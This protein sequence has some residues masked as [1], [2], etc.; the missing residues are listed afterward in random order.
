MD[1]ISCCCQGFLLIKFARLSLSG[2]CLLALSTCLNSLCSCWAKLS[3]ASKVRGFCGHLVT[4]AG[5]TCGLI[6]SWIDGKGDRRLR[7]ST[8]ETCGCDSW[9]QAAL[10]ATY[11]SRSPTDFSVLSGRHFFLFRCSAVVAE[12]ATHLKCC[13]GEFLFSETFIIIIFSLWQQS[14]RIDRPTI[15]PISL[16][17]AWSCCCCEQSFLVLRKISGEFVFSVSW[18]LCMVMFSDFPCF[19]RPAELA[20]P[21]AI[22][23]PFFIIR[24]YLLRRLS[25]LWINRWF[26]SSFVVCIV[27]LERRRHPY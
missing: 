7:V 12:T 11:A 5:L 24:F 8:L 21:S 23:A 4:S 9:L 2:T 16:N 25:H 10:L 18:R 6:S 20:Q 26:D 14:W 1:Q 17:S 13:E 22:F 19:T 27:D 3:Q 15:A